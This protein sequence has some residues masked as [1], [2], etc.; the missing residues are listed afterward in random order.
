MYGNTNGGPPWNL[1]GSGAGY[2][3]F[4]TRAG[5]RY[6]LSLLFVARASFHDPSAGLLPLDAPRDLDAREYN[7]QLGYV[8]HN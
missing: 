2:Y 8:L 4:W 3:P 7:I 1:S 5:R 6:H